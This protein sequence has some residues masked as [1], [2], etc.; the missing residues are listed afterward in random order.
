MSPTD[1]SSPS[2]PRGPAERLR[3]FNEALRRSAS[4][5]GRD[6]VGWLQ[7]LAAGGRAATAIYQSVT[8]AARPLA[9][10][11]HQAKKKGLGVMIEVG[12]VRMI[13]VDAEVRLRVLRVMQGAALKDAV[14]EEKVE[15]SELDA[16]EEVRREARNARRSCA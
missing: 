11:V 9:L 12:G 13:K 7:E 10:A 1:K 16:A 8:D 2:S 15:R 5:A 6:L 4:V 14:E 3:Y